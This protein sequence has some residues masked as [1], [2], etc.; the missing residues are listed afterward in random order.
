VS[1]TI[2]APDAEQEF[3]DID[4]HF[5]R[6]IARFGGDTSLIETLT[7]LLSRAVRE[8]HTCLDVEEWNKT[9]NAPIPTDW[10]EKVARSAAF[11][12]PDAVTPIVVAGNRLFLR[13]YWDYEQ[14]LAQSVLIRAYRNGAYRDRS[15]TQADAIDAALV[16]YFSIL[17]GGPGTGKT[18]TVLKILQGFIELR[19]KHGAPRIAL[20]APTGKAAARI[21]E[22]LREIHQDERLDS[23]LRARLPQTASTIHRLLGAK[24]DSVFFRHDARN[25]LP[26]DLLII[27]EASMVPLP[28]MAKVF[29]ALPPSAAVILVGDHDQLAAVEPGAVLADLADAASA[30]GGPLANALFVLK[31]NFRFGNENAIYQFSNAVRLGDS[32]EALRLLGDK[33]FTELKGNPLPSTAQLPAAIGKV[34]AEKYK[35][36]LGHKDPVAALKEFSRFRILCAVRQGPFGV[37]QL[38]ETIEAELYRAGL[39]SDPT[40][41]YAGKPLLISRNDYQAQ[42]FNGDIG[43]VLPDPNDTGQGQLWAWF[44]GTDGQARRISLGRLP[45]HELAYAMTVHKAQGSELERVLLLLP[46]RDS[47]VLNRELI[48]T[49]VTRASKQVDVWFNDQVLSASIARQAIRRSGLCDAL[50]R[51]PVA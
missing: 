20:A 49:G 31:E 23:N 27:D 44:I 18:T 19:G 30:S 42:L 22:L 11:G 36:Y 6:F 34:A 9:A 37:N 1:T 4:R 7:A 40:M 2:L 8:G 12:R 21:Q 5:G 48:Y 26:L 14:S 3:A 17:S 45:E 32:K 25:P 24:A 41:S 43:V 39:I 50:E 38:N 13:R 28:L 10:K 29:D 51:K 16:N 15:G 47:P 35:S 46:D 33:N